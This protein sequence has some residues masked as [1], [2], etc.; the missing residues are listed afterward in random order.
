MKQVFINLIKNAAEAIQS[1]GNIFI[2]TRL[3]G[4]EPDGSMDKKD[5]ISITIRDDGPG[6]P[7]S[8]ESRLFEPFVSTKGDE[9]AGLGLSIVYKIL[10]EIKGTISCKT[11]KNEG[12]T[13]LITLPSESES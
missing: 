2:E 10:K 9:H 8:V 13:F 3:D 6:L 5:C 7:N 1:D 4:L 12:T 11:E